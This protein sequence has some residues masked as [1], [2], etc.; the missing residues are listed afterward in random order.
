MGCRSGVAGRLLFKDVKVPTENVV[1]RI[2]GFYTVFKTMMIIK[3]PGTAAMTIGNA[4][5]AL[6]I[7]T[8]YPTK[9]NAFG[10]PLNQL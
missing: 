10:T 6:E 1:G 9:R 3:R 8:A 5:P 4:R 7:A 2:N